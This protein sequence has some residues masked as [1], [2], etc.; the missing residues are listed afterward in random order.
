M[1]NQVL[2]KKQIAN[3]ILMFILCSILYLG[4]LFIIMFFQ[5]TSDTIDYIAHNGKSMLIVGCSV[6]LFA[7]LLYAYFF[8][9]NKSVLARKRKVF[10]IY[11]MFYIATIISFLSGKFIDVDA[12]PYGIIVLLA[13]TFV[14]RREAI[15]IN[16]VYT[17][18][19]FILDRF[20]NILPVMDASAYA[21]LIGSFCVGMITVF[22]SG[23]VKSRIQ[24]VMLVFVLVIPSVLVLALF[25][26]PEC[27]SMSEVYSILLSGVVGSTISIL[28]YMFFIPVFEV[29][30]AELTTFRLREL[31]SDDAKL[32]KLLK[33]KAPGTYH[34]CVIVAQL[35]EEVARCLGEDPEL[36]RAAAFYHD[37]GKLKDPEMFTENQA[38]NNPHT[39]LTPELS[40]DIIRSH[41]RD[42]AK[43]IR[44]NHLPEFF[45]EIALQHHGTLP[46]KYFYAKALRMSDGELN[47]A[48][49]SYEGPTPT[50]KIA[51]ILMIADAAEA[52]T[53]SLPV[54]SPANVEKLVRSLIEERL[55]LGQFE[56]CNITMHELSQITR[57]M[58]TQLTDVYHTRI[59]YPKLKVSKKK[60]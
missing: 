7:G 19:Q 20:T 16:V 59:S 57:I 42:G 28:T 40:V 6:A 10:E 15:V 26:I 34:H 41:A 13:A 44:Q 51:A 25:R 29:I 39:H 17:L 4:I 24:T 35:V 9:E 54:R 14:G 53:R 55:D 11:L 30:F 32:I 49:Y 2:T 60:K 1:N 27:D 56:N 50:S 3:S 22:V 47:I 36:A 21:Y 31:T 5:N 52:A 43:L 45:A 12:R 18:L 48:T 46:I 23:Y 33:D 37:M 38:G 8:A 58:V